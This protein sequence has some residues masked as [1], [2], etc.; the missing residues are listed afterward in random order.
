RKLW[1]DEVDGGII[2][3]AVILPEVGPDHPHLAASLASH[4]QRFGHPPWLLAGDRGMASP[5]N[6]ALAKQAGVKRVVIPRAGQASPERQQEERTRWFRRGFRFRAGIEGRI[7]VLRR[8]FG[9]DRCRDHGE[10]GMARW[11]G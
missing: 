8:D 4:R 7:H 6:E 5:E 3:R 10:P 2:S 1:L 9:L 11:V